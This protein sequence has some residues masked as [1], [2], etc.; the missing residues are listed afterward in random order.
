MSNSFSNQVL[1][2]ISL[3]TE[4]DRYDDG[5]VYVLSK[6]LDEKVARASSRAARREAHQAHAGPVRIP[7]DLTTG[8]VQ[9]ELL[10]LLSHDGLAFDRDLALLRVA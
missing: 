9:A 1:A 10:P 2:Q 8:A 3:W 7:R 4:R 6:E 5:K